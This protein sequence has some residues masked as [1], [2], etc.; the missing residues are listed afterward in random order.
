MRLQNYMR[1]VT[2]ILAGILG[3]GNVFAQPSTFIHIQSENNKAFTVQ[4]KG[5]SFV[6]SSTGYLLLP[7]VPAGDQLLAVSFPGNNQPGYQFAIAVS[8]KPRGFSLKQALD[9]SWSFFDMID[10]TVIKGSPLASTAKTEPKEEKLIPIPAEPEKIQS[11]PVET[12]VKG[13]PLPAEKKDPV[14]VDPGGK[15]KL[16]PANEAAPSVT[17]SVETPV[18]AQLLPA[19]KKETPV[20]VDPG[21]KKRLPV[22]KEVWYNSV[23]KIF[24]RTGTS[25]I[26]QVYIVVNNGKADTVAL[27]IPEL[28]VPAVKQTA[29]RISRQFSGREN[30]LLLAMNPEAILPVKPAGIRSK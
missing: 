14:V 16:T 17:T 6:S 5:N 23:Q 2:V 26:D 3:T 12:P 19:E 18:K 10:F 27:F 22:E 9:N 15:K 24:D 8:D 21:G 4:W 29:S 25:G 28:P 20:V 1:L 11:V 30:F 13:Q 7:Q